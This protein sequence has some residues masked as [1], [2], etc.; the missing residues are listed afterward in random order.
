MNASRL[1]SEDLRLAVMAQAKRE[2][3]VYP[4]STLSFVAGLADQ[5]HMRADEPS[6]IGL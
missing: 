6:A 3:A 4:D 2:K 1:Q 5:G